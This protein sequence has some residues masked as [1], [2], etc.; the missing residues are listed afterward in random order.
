[1][2][3]KLGP[4]NLQSALDK[5]AEYTFS[6]FQEGRTRESEGIYTSLI[7]KG[8]NNHLTYG[9]LGIIYGIE[10]RWQELIAIL[11]NHSS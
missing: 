1:M 3:A 7:K 8:T 4:D 2:N 5:Q 6:L 10:G 11:E 9:N